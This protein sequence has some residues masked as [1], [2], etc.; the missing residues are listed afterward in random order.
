MNQHR[1]AQSAVCWLTPVPFASQPA[2]T[3]GRDG[4]HCSGAKSNTSLSSRCSVAFRQ[5]A[6]LL[7][8]TLF[9][10]L[11]VRAQ[12]VGSITGT[13]TDPSGAVIANAIVTATRVETGVAQSTRTGNAGTY[14]IPNLVVGTYNVT[15]EVRGFKPASASR[16][17]LDVSQQRQV[18]F[19]LSL[20][21]VESTVE[22][23]TAPP[24]INTTDATIAGLVSE[25]QVET[26]PLNGR[27]I[28]G[29]VMM[30]PGMAQDTG[31]MGWMGPQWIANG[32]RGETLTGTLDNADISDAE[33][34]T[35]QFTNFNLDAIA[36]FKV[37]QNNY[38]AQYGQGG[39]TITE[40]VSKTGT[41]QFH[42]SAFEFLRN[43]VFDARNYFATS[44]PPFK[45]N[46]FG[47]TFGGPL[48]K[49]KT[50][51]FGEYAGLRQRLGE[52]DV[53]VV[54]TAAQRQGQV[55]IGVTDINGVTQQF[56]YQV[57]LNSVAQEVLSKYPM[58][59]QPN[60][61]YGA[62]TFNFLFSQPT[63]DNQFS[64]RLD[65]HFGNDSLFARASYENQNALETDKWAA[66][67]GGS[68]FSSAN[69]GQARNYAIS[70]TH[71]FTPTL[72]NV[73][74]F[75]LNRGI[76]GVPEV[77][78]EQN[79]TATSFNDG[80]LQGWGPDT[81]ETKYVV[82][83]FDY[84]DDVSWTRGRH[85]FNV[86]G[87]FRREWDNGTGVTYIGPSGVF[88]FNAG[89][90]LSAA[91]PSTDGGPALAAGSASPSGMISMM[92]GDDVN[93]GRA[94]A[95][96]GYG[97]PGG[98]QVWWYLRRWTTAG[99]VQDDIRA[100]RRLTLNLGLRYEY[101]SVPWE[102]KNRLARPDDQ[103][104]LFGTFVVNPQPLWKPDRIAGDFAP[105]FGMALNLGSN[106]VLRGGFAT[107]TNMIP[108][109]YP[110]QALV[111]FPIASLNYLPNAPYSLTPQSVSLPPLTSTSGQPL[112]VNGT[113]SIPPNTP[114]NV[115]PYAAILGPVSGDYPSDA[116]KNGY[117]I[118]ANVTLEHQ[119]FNS[120]ALQASY[121][122]NNGVFLYNMTY[123]NAFTG[124]ESQYT[125]YTNTTPGLG[126][127][128]VF[129]NG[130]HSTY[131]GLQ[132]QMRKISASHG[133]QFQA[134]Y[135]WAKDLTD[136]DAVWSA[137]GSSGGISQNNP[138]CVP[139]ERSRASYSVAQRFVANFEYTLPFASLLATAPKR[140]TNGW[141][142]LGIFSAQSGFPFTVVSPYGSLEYGYDTLDGFGARPNLLQMPTK[143]PNAGHSPQFFSD[144]VINGSD[145]G[146]NDGFFGTP[147]VMNA[148]V[149]VLPT[150]GNLGRN[151]FTG[152]GWSNF[153]FSLVKDTAI[154]ETTQLQF[155]AEFFNI[156]NQATF[157]TPGAGGIATSGSAGGVSLGSPNFGISTSTATAERQIQLGLR[158][159]F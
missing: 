71:V 72:L 135:T 76:E 6:W 86:G 159:I 28:S 90:P 15:V 108:T 39:G 151:T 81:F 48:K 147:T 113:S 34:G 83:L 3:V 2:S 145:Y 88:N 111:N 148:G 64:V 120:I 92:E 109:V 67:L 110:D 82:T 38:S 70:D 54:P 127:L 60:G 17:T 56:N 78:A 21:G 27:N 124:A 91:I 45:R 95:V 63:D 117:T 139:C 89:T 35:L 59:N 140:L 37:L 9:F 80:S 119:F 98:G 8:L 153:D 75:T 12:A 142:I 4:T 58:P 136:A 77:S 22:V 118:S 73:F 52:P 61:I 123:P 114:V 42:G 69:V 149:P 104:S 50:F 41:N 130:A 146:L 32:N 16:I 158:F 1:F 87:Q 101:A 155:R 132:M 126:E 138:E 33:M 141:M 36:E 125:P 143:A 121:I 85:S 66:E 74:T 84:K 65:Q 62:N 144:A 29:L 106:T 134:N 13:V 7:L 157:A 137:G 102:L 107:F 49:D 10:H 53:V 51:F 79:T 99:Y 152:P 100:I 122:A 128:Q 129:Y 96:P 11:E 14:T 150:P 47:A 57:P 94:T 40:M 20:V 115:A 23:D 19:K 5:V 26:L 156:F 112:A 25:E 31:S 68:S 30:E 154:T 44:V 116:M 97:P 43:N 46:E 55:T 18:D 93:Y 133:L 131:N 105:R 24:L 103:G